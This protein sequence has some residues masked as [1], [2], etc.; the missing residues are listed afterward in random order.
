MT[1]IDRPDT[2][3]EPEEHKYTL[4]DVELSGISTVAKVGG[5]L[6]TW[7]RASAWGFR[8]GYEGAYDV[9]HGTPVGLGPDLHSKDELRAE[10]NKRR[11]T[12]WGK[13][14][15]AATR[16]TWVHD[17]LEALAQRGELPSSFPNEE[18]RGHARAVFAW[19]VK[20]RP[21]FL[22][23]EV[24]VTSRRL[25]VAGR[26]DIEA[27]IDARKLVPLFED[28]ECYQRVLVEDDAIYEQDSRCLIDLKTSK[29]VYPETHFPQLS[30]YEICRQ[31]MHF[32]PTRAQFILNTH[33]DGTFDFVPSWSTG[34]EF[35]GYL[36]A[37]R[38]I[39][40]VESNDPEVRRRGRRE[41]EVLALLVTPR[42]FKDINPKGMDQGRLKGLLMSMKKQGKITCEKG[43]WRPSV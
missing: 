17:V 10:L 25:G 35:E 9:L 12:P 7:E 3:F 20:Y 39:R 42:R 43:I 18:T 15:D 23:T 41:E 1:V 21:S 19:Y 33:P 13:R 16:G 28:Y 6:G 4:D 37:F 38:S 29:G 2:Q 27:N 40:S 34:E 26:Y 14:D 22:A 5:A 31:E 24:Q 36:C 11:L 32:P 30:G 8:I